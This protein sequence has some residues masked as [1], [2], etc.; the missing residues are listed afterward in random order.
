MESW[1]LGCW[2]FSFIR[3]SGYLFLTVGA[4]YCKRVGRFKHR[5]EAML[6]SFELTYY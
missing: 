5:N 2:K 3:N 6:A 1:T 4:R